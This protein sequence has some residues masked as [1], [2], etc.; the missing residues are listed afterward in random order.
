VAAGFLLLAAGIGNAAPT[1]FEHYVIGGDTISDLKASI[2]ATAPR[3]GNALGLTNVVISPDFRL[4]ETDGTCRAVDVT[5]D[6][7]ITVTLP[8]VEVMPA[9]FESRW[10]HIH[11]TVRDHEMMHAKIAEVYAGRI[12]TAIREASSEAG[13][14]A[15]KE[16]VLADIRELQD[17][18]RAMQRNYDI[19]DSG[20]VM[21]LLP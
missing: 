3:G 1:R 8:K 4:A 19:I 15:L 13:C 21:S 11:E 16:K 5:V 20:R 9:G 14:A 18:H 7:E 2:V 6:L 12:E 17:R 10:Q